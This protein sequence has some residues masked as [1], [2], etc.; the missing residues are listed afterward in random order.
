M[1]TANEVVNSPVDSIHADV[2]LV[3]T[4][5]TRQMDTRGGPLAMYQAKGT[6]GTQL[7]LKVFRGVPIQ[8][9]AT[10]QVMQGKH[11]AKQGNQGRWFHDL[12]AEGDAVLVLG[13]QQ[14]PPPQSAAPPPQ[15]YGAPPAGSAQQP[16]PVPAFQAPPGQ[17]DGPAPCTV[18]DVDNL[19]ANVRA[20]CA[21]TD[22]RA[23]AQVVDTCLIAMFRGQ[24]QR[25]APTSQDDVPM[26][27]EEDDIP[28]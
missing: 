11:V 4:K 21:F 20:I 23:T 19:V 8:P 22:E 5:L 16:P 27:D 15:Q 18:A 7:G 12:E 2:Q 13:G 26:P 28:F 24:L 17:V 9:G 6:D 3:V 25:P 14:A 10:V 1:A